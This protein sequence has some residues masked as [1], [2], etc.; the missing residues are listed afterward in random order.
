MTGRE[1]PSDEV[2]MKRLISREAHIRQGAHRPG[3]GQSKGLEADAECVNLLLFHCRFDSLLVS[4]LNPGFS[5]VD[6]QAADSDNVTPGKPPTT[7]NSLSLNIEGNDVGYLADFI[8]GTPPRKFSILMDSGSAD[9]W[10]GGE[11]CQSLSVKGADCVSDS[12]QF[13]S[14]NAHTTRHVGQS[15]IP[16]TQ[17][18]VLIY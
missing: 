8:I 1:G 2:L 5:P 13:S 14:H 12:G 15:Y 17:V 9:F 11:Q 7:Q 6:Q 18:L 10:V 3:V 16:W 4:R